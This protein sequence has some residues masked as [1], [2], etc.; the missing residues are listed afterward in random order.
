M[1]RLAKQLTLAL[2]DDDQGDDVGDIAA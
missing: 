1:R 2:T